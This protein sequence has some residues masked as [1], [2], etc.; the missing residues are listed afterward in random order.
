[1]CSAMEA[2]FQS[3]GALPAKRPEHVLSTV[4]CLRDVIYLGKCLSSSYPEI[5][6]SNTVA[7]L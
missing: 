2:N 5:N 4:T 1:M 3:D 7:P 6:D